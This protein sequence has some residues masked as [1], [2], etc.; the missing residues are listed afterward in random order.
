MNK[1]RRRVGRRR[2]R[3]EKRVEQVLDACRQWDAFAGD[4]TPYEVAAIPSHVARLLLVATQGVDGRR[5]DIYDA[6]RVGASWLVR[7]GEGPRRDFL[8]SLRRVVS[9]T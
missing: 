4:S 5:R 6:R 1:R 2:T 9:G 7:A 3:N 8:A